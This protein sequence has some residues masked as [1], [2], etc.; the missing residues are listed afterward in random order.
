[1][2]EGFALNREKLI[3][4]CPVCGNT[5]IYYEVG[6]YAGT[7]YHCKECGYIGAFVVEANEEMIEKIK[8][9]YKR[10]REDEE[11]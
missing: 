9:K 11:K 6:G 3:E 5:D 1:L 10:E 2:K 4:V 7:V 8:E